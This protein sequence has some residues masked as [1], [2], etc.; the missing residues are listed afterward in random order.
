MDLREKKD[1]F[2][3]RHPWETARL[4]AIEKIIRAHVDLKT[5]QTSLDVGCG[6]TFLTHSLAGRLD[7]EMD[8]VDINLSL[9]QIQSFSNRKVHLHNS[10][11]QLGRYDLIIMSDVI[12]HVKDDVPFL[13]KITSQYLSSGGYVLIIVPAFQFLSSSHDTFLGHFRRYNAK[14]LKYLTD[15]AALTIVSGGYLFMSLLPVRFLI[16]S[17]ERLVPAKEKANNGVGNW[18]AGNGM[19]HFIECILNL[20]AYILLKL[21]EWKIKIPGLSLWI[22][23]RKQ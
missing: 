21:A 8:G 6:D 19:T 14:Q 12:E 13:T 1:A 15:Q 3:R 17:F 23:C 16:S 20:D 4:K 18:K 9:E 5:V 10:Y 2:K 22:L 11:D 7:L